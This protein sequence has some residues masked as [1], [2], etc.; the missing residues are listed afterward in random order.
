MN[1]T[2]ISVTL[3]PLRTGFGR[4]AFKGL[5][6]GTSWTLAASVSSALSQWLLL[7]V[8]AKLGSSEMVGQLALSFAIVAPIQILTD[9]A[10]RPSL[11]TDARSD[12]QFRDYLELRALSIVV[13]VAA[14]T[15]AALLRDGGAGLILLAVGLQKAAESASD[16]WFGVFQREERLS[17]MGQ[18]VVLRSAAASVAFVGVMLL[19]QNLLFACLAGFA[20]RIAVLLFHDSARGLDLVDLAR[21]GPRRVGRLMKTSL[22]LAVGLFLMSFTVNIPRYFV[23]KRMGIATLGVFAALVYVFQAGAMLVDAVSQTAC[24]RLARYHLMGDG[25]SFRRIVLK[26]IYMALAA[27]GLGVAVALAGG[28]TLLRLI[29]SAAFANEAKTFLWLSVCALPWYCSSVFGYVLVAR[30]QMMALFYCQVA[31]LAATLT[32]SYWF[33]GGGQLSDACRIVFLTYAV[34]LTLYAFCLWRVPAAGESLK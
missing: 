4:I 10:L 24:A 15:L 26:L 16:L 18:S 21:V 9:M 27:S 19:S 25:A 22:P 30:R 2:P 8:T 5:A 6:S 20:A 31:S 29:Y 34:L 1:L 23:E 7:M 33:I 11:A 17:W 3:T 12:F 13:M 28:S 32:G 14:V